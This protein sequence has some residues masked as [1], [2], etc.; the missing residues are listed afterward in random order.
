METETKK[1]VNPKFLMFMEED[2]I[3]TSAISRKTDVIKTSATIQTTDLAMMIDL[4]RKLDMRG[5]IGTTDEIGTTG[6]IR[7][8]ETTIQASVDKSS[9]TAMTAFYQRY[10]DTH[11]LNVLIKNSPLYSI[12]GMR[13]HTNS[14]C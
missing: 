10:K 6:L 7:K 14:T 13:I 4:I 2:S 1:F 9:R 8:T 12:L 3:L 11:E 5:L